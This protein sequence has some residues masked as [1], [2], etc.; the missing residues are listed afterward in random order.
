[1]S[2]VKLIQPQFC[3]HCRGTREQCEDNEY[4]QYR[5]SAQPQ[6]PPLQVELDTLRRWADGMGYGD[7]RPTRL[8]AQDLLACV[9]ENESLK[10]KLDF[11]GEIL[12]KI[13]VYGTLIQGEKPVDPPPHAAVDAILAQINRAEKAEAEIATIRERSESWKSQAMRL[14]DVISEASMAMM[15]IPPEATREALAQCHIALQNALADNGKLG[16]DL[17]EAYSCPHC[18]HAW[19]VHTDGECGAYITSGRS[20][21]AICGC[22][23]RT[24]EQLRDEL[25][26]M[27]AERDNLRQDSPTSKQALAAIEQMERAEKAEAE[28]DKALELI[29]EYRMRERHQGCY[30]LSAWR[31]DGEDH[32]C[33]TC[34]KADALLK[35]ES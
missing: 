4:C 34:I 2:K 33:P 35:E 26:T 18:D 7:S 29:R 8:V 3:P 23:Q 31:F 5:W 1:M 11:C 27:K 19:D 30:D 32:R 24:R 16:A 22:T 13:C 28:R 10:A 17:R 15:G 12:G 9:A 20:M 25:D 14:Q 21:G 6:L